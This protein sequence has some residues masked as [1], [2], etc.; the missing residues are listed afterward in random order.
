MQRCGENHPGQTE[1]E[2][3][4]HFSFHIIPHCGLC[5]RVTQDREEAVQREWQGT[6]R[7][8]ARDALCPAVGLPGGRLGT[9]LF[10][11]PGWVSVLSTESFPSA[12][13]VCL[14]RLLPGTRALSSSVQGPPH[15]PPRVLAPPSQLRTL[16]RASGALA[17]PGCFASPKSLKTHQLYTHK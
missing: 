15:A 7:E 5:F 6:G 11:L 10:L 17:R 13:P 8:G 2:G 14:P 4:G 12:H 16:P 1:A 9:G 3:K